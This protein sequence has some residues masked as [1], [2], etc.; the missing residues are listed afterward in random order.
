MYVFV[1]KE[2]NTLLTRFPEYYHN[3]FVEIFSFCFYLWQFLPL[4]SRCNWPKTHKSFKNKTRTSVCRNRA[5]Y[6]Q[7]RAR[8][9]LRS[10]NVSKLIILLVCPSHFSTLRNCNITNVIILKHT[11]VCIARHGN[12]S[13]F[14][15]VYI[16]YFFIFCRFGHQGNM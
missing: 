9:S 1:E 7:S 5:L 11:P 8:L 3:I 16:F 12:W 13:Y 2:S 4:L 14:S 15:Y 10:G 6:A